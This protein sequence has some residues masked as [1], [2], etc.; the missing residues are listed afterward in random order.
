MYDFD[1]YINLIKDRL[2]EHRF[3]HSMCVAK[4]ARE[5]AVKYGADPDMPYLDLRRISLRASLQ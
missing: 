4:R 5:L 1:K 3:Y 2:S